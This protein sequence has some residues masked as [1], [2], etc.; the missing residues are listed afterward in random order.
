MKS[1]HLA[2]AAV[3]ALS[4]TAFVTAEVYNDATGDVASG[5]NNPQG[6]LDLGLAQ[7]SH[8]NTNITFMLTINGDGFSNHN[9]GKYMIGIATGGDQGSTTNNPW[10]RPISMNAYGGMTR[11]IGSWVDNG[12][13]A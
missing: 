5:I 11:W 12:G 13:G 8:D 6:I 3:A 9:W 10:D 1:I 7:V 2:C 4:T